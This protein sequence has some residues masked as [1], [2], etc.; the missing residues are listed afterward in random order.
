MTYISLVAHD[1]GRMKVTTNHVRLG[2][3]TYI[4]HLA[5]LDRLRP[6]PEAFHDSPNAPTPCLGGTREKLLR[7]IFTWFDN[8]DPSGE[9]VFWLN[10]LAGTGK[11]A[12]ARTVA[13][14]V[15]Q[16][17]RL[18]ATFFFS[19]NT[20]AT[21]AP[22]AIIPT[23]VSQ[24]ARYWPSIKPAICAAVS[25][26]PLIRDR[27][28]KA[29]AKILFDNVP[30]AAVLDG[31]FLVVLDAL[32]ECH[33]ENGRQG[34]E[35]VPM[36]L[37][38]F[39]SLGCVKFL[40]TSRD[41]GPIRRMFDTF[42]SK[43][44]LHDIEQ[45]I[46][47]SDIHHYLQHSFAELARE[48][49]LI[50]PF[51][52]ARELNELVRRAGSLFIYAATVT[53]WIS[54][55]GARPLLRLQQVL[56][57][58]E[59]EMPYQ[60][61][62]LDDMYCEILCQAAKTSGNPRKHECA[63][64]NVISTVVLL[65]E[66]VRISALAILAREQDRTDELLPLLSAILL[67]DEPAPVRLFHPSFPEFITSEERCRDERFLV[68]ASEGH[69]RLAAQCLEVMNMHLRENICDIKDPSLLNTEVHLLQDTLERV[70]PAELRYA[71][72]HWH[73]HLRLADVTSP[74]LVNSLETFCM[75]HL[76]HWLELLSLLNELPTA[77][78]EM[79]L[80]LA[81]L[82]VCILHSRL[83]FAFL[84]SYTSQ[85]HPERLHTSLVVLLADTK[86]LLSEYHTAIDSN[87]LHVY[88]S[89]AVTMPICPL[90]EGQACKAAVR[91]CLRT[92]RARGWILH[93]LILEGHTRDVN[94]V[95]FSPDGQS[96]VSGSDDKTVRVWD[97]TTGTGR[98]IMHGHEYLVRSVAFSPDGQFIVSGSADHTVRVWDATT[99]TERHI[100][101]GHKDWVRSA[102]FS[103]NGL[104][105]VS[106][107]DDKTMRV[108][109]ATTGTER[110][111]MSGHKSQVF[112]VAFS[113]DGQSIV[114]GSYDK[115]VR[116]WDAATGTERHTM[117]GHEG[118]VLSV[119]FSP[120]GQS[121]VSGSEDKTV[122]VWDATTGT[123]RHTLRGHDSWVR[124]VGFSSQGRFI[125]SGSDDKTLRVW[126]A[127]TGTERHIMHGHEDDVNSVAFSP[128]GR[129]IVSGSFDQT[130][131]VWDATTG[132]EQH[133]IHGHKSRVF[134][135]AFSPDGQSIVSGSYD[136]TV[137]VWDATTGTGRHT[138]HGHESFVSS[139][140]FSPNGQFIVSGSED[141]TVR[142]WDATTGTERHAMH[143]HEDDV[144]SVAFSPDGQFIVSRSTFNI[145]RVWDAS[146]GME[147]R[148]APHPDPSRAQAPLAIVAFAVDETMSWVSRISSR[149]TRQRLCWLPKQYRGREIAF[150]DQ[151]VCIGGENGAI[152]I[153][154]FSDV[155]FSYE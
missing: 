134:C 30:W 60:H 69:L 86:Q 57:K 149:G 127:A 1:D 129:S 47:Q 145:V 50:H 42:Q 128:D 79:P 72:R 17:G 68:K 63:L 44:A 78:T 62:F 45:T 122:R 11:S 119:V 139:V 46:V 6:V 114:S 55:P 150:H 81:Y 90:W 15:K 84:T 99:G 141:N 51:P 33:V 110:H 32:D 73:A 140:A 12:V 41:E 38:T 49:N 132:T 58:D 53:K 34:G 98:H 100:I 95:A 77:Q 56:D 117:H 146:T 94:S 137:R 130:A 153:L 5:L 54:D 37:D 24:L 131:R 143:G 20:V 102:V 133:V 61:K 25:S 155:P 35:A 82:R 96:I 135:V 4:F 66:P 16:Q 125:V 13:D 106:C 151:T 31:P 103:P 142:V 111:V 123:E 75:T 136:K 91:A 148:T 120:D 70:A 3:L 43:I 18:A 108:W 10:G 67:V 22:S 28:V 29:Q 154:D 101:H 147:Q 59:D 65:Q 87:A 88:Q 76:L 48:R 118:M 124:S 64:R 92:P 121:I 152:T 26:D 27:G 115:T 71:C 74:G 21:R 113:P 109:D 52:P 116:V 144:R 39:R 105:I 93:S 126:D 85:S 9:H 97:A 80:L 83:L 112:C 23:I 2:W 19:R 107:S 14:H 36:L 8:P 104:S 40:I 138:M 7:D 89:A